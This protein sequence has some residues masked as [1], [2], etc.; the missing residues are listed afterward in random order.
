MTALKDEPAGHIRSMSEFFAIAHAIEHD[1][2][3]RYTQTSRQL[4]A[5]GETAL[6]DLFDTLA[7]TER[8]HIRQIDQWASDNE[9]Q[10]DATLPWPIP[11]TFDATPT[12]MARTKLLTPYQALASAVR[13]EQRAFAFWSYVAAHAETNEIRKAA[14]RMA[15]E[16]LE[17]V[18]LLRRE[19]RKAF[20]AARLGGRPAGKAPLSLAAL[21]AI[22]RR[23]GDL[24]ESERESA[25]VQR[26]IAPLA[27]AA[28]ETA[29]K[30]EALH[31]ASGAT[32]LVPALPAE[33]M[34]DAV[35]LAEY[36]ADAYL[37]LAET[38]QDTQALAV[39][40]EL[41]KTAI[42]RLG[43]LRPAGDADPGA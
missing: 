32:V 35:A 18:S 7:E 29:A 11:D 13:H 15:L 38:A 14:E 23:L 33:R 31:A 16:E 3:T 36:L 22:E 30:L 19:R 34:N 39:A 20:H 24:I 43:T 12:E 10:A 17:H 4:R 9:G 28:R 1:A 6:A 5:Q 27:A 2:A 42:S 26:S 25:S 37:R 8:G 21:A 41:A 40:Q